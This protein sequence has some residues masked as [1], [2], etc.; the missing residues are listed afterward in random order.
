M[1]R[2]IQ[3]TSRAR[4]RY[5]IWRGF[6][7]SIVQ[8]SA[9]AKTVGHSPAD[10]ALA[11]DPFKESDQQQPEIHPRGQRRSPQ[12]R[13]IEIAALLLAELIEPRVVQHA[14][15]L[16]VKG[17]PRCFRPLAR[18]KQ[19][20][21]LLSGSLLPHRL[22]RWYGPTFVDGS[23]VRHGLVDHCKILQAR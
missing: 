15:Q 21:L 14:V 22:G 6:V 10:A 3:Q 11:A 18:V 19:L 16:L 4:D 5:V 20:F 8:K 13:V 2:F 7:E 9:Q 17:M 23:E 1:G 12:L